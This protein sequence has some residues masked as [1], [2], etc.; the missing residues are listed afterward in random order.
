MQIESLIKIIERLPEPRRTSHGN[1][2]H[3]LVDIVVIGLC[4][5]MCG[6]DS[7]DAMEYVGRT[8]EQYFKDFLD[9]PNGIPDSD[10][11]RRVFE[12]LSP[13]GLAEC[14]YEWLG[15]QKPEQSVV[16][17]DGKTICGSSSPQH[18][19]FHV[20]SAFVAEHHLTLG[21]ITVPAKTNEITAIPELLDLID[22]EGD[23]VTLDAMGCQKKIVE[24][25]HRKK[26]DYAIALKG[27]QG[28]FHSDVAL[29]FSEFSEEHAKLNTTEKGH[30]RV[31]TRE[32]TLCTDISWLCKA[33]SWK[34]LKAI[35]MVKSTVYHTKSRKEA[36]DT[37]YYITSLD[38]IDA[39][40]NAVRKHW[41]I[42]NQ[43]HWNL[44][45]IFGED[46]CSAKKDNSALN[47]NVLRKIAL[48][49]LNSART[50]RAT[51]KLLMFK[52]SLDPV[53]MIDMLLQWKK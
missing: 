21:E 34:G 2:R 50:G 9:L 13:K 52:A 22:V 49:L 53:A 8:R 40:A 39:F 26:A 45:V 29:Y 42:E 51:K 15:K 41:G 48:R 30:G 37:R 28:E 19:A 43:L 38:R 44:D 10:T 18:K 46:G 14:L 16:A 47:L 33:D 11:F 27:N 24:K 7:F 12:R 23:V 32:Y 25:I 31:E 35:G 36:T 20:V 6:G 5:V 1:I 4:T 17:I 3:K